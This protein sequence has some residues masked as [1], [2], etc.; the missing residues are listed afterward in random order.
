MSLSRLAALL[1]ATTA[2]VAP[3]ARAGPVQERTPAA[4][5]REAASEPL[6]LE[7]DRLSYDAARREVVA[8]GNVRLESRGRVLTADRLVYRAR[9]DRVLA[10]G[11]VR[12]FLPEGAVFYGERLEVTGDLREG[13]VTGVMARLDVRGRLAAAAGAR[14]ADRWTVL[15]RAVFTTCRE[16]GEGGRPPWRLRAARVIHDAK[17]RTLVYENVTFELGGLPVFWLPRFEHPDPSV[18]RRTGLLT[19]EGG[20]DTELGFWLRWPY[21]VDLAPNRDLTLTPMAAAVRAPCCAWNSA[22][23]S[24]SGARSSAVAS[25]G[26]RRRSPHRAARAGTCRAG[27]WRGGGAMPS[28]PKT[29]RDSTSPGLPTTPTSTPSRSPIWTCWRTGCGSSATAA[30]TCSAPRPSPSRG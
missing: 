25:P 21:Y 29:A 13:F 28:R 27:T 12:L 4:V 24:A 15:E 26:P 22:T 14:V 16:C 9:E 2:L 17:T 1:L 8:E 5:A 3:A 6:L 18:E 10:E 7:A 23:S 11:N 30:G 20:S 19:P